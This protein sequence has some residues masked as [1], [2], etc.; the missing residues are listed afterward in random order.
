M[1]AIESSGIRR[2]FLVAVSFVA[3]TA[4]AEPSHVVL[5]QG[6]V[7]EQRRIIIYVWDGFRPDSV[8]PVDTPNLYAMR[9]AGVNFIDNHATYPTFTM[10]NAA[11]FA[12][13]SFGGTTGYYGNTLWQ[14]LR[15]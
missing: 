5:A 13:G 11:S 7:P 12:T 8:N 1:P 4:S 15:T 10:M 3:I 9:E 2:C 6:A 14:P